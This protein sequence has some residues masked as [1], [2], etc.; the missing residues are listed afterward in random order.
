MV[1]RLPTLHQ[2]RQLPLDVALSIESERRSGSDVVVWSL[3]EKAVKVRDGFY[4]K[5]YEVAGGAVYRV[6]ARRERGPWVAGIHL[7]PRGGVSGGKRKA[8]LVIE[9]DELVDPTD[10]DEVCDLAWKRYGLEG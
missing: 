1:A 9:D 8:R 4:M 2:P 5:H 3:E 7:E 6:E 10:G